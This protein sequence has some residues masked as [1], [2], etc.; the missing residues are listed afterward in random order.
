MINQTKLDEI[1]LK[2]LRLIQDNARITT[3][4]IAAKVN[5]STTPVF[6]RMKRLESEGYIKKYI[7]ILDRDKLN[8]GF[9]VFCSVKLKQMNK[10][11]AEEFVRRI[12]EVPQVSECYNVAGEYDYMLKIYAPDIKAYNDFLINDLGT[13]D[14]IGSILST[15]V[16][17]EIKQSYGFDL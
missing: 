17:S 4:Q 10:A 6:E 2:I 3:K 5:L 1:D 11:I 15:F 13:I 14:S 8:R 9:A 12:K 16:M 7:A